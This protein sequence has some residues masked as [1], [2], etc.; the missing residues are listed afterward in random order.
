MGRTFKRVALDSLTLEDI[1]KHRLKLQKIGITDPRLL[2]DNKI[3]KFMN[4]KS[5]RNTKI[6][7]LAEILRVLQQ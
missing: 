5:V 1:N 3:I 6:I 7:P 2:T 4:E